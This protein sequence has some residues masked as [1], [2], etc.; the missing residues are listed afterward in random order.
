MNDTHGR[1]A[2]GLHIALA[3][4][5][6]IGLALVALVFGGLAA[7]VGMGSDHD[8]TAIAALLATILGAVTAVLA[9]LSVAELVAAIMYLRGSEGAR[10]WLVVISAFSLLHVPLGTAIGLYS[11]WALLRP[12]AVPRRGASVTSA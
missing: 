10:I 7:I 9:L 6:L 2:A 8:A 5:D 1:I 12:E 11:L 4:L 3:V